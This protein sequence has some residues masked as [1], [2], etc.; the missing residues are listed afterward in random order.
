MSVPVS[1]CFHQ[2][3]DVYRFFFM[4][5]DLVGLNDPTP[6]DDGFF[7]LA[8]IHIWERKTTNQQHIKCGHPPV[9]YCHFLCPQ[10]L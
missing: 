3:W 4:D 6:V 10:Y 1:N 7:Y 8:N 2:K 5:K 9:R